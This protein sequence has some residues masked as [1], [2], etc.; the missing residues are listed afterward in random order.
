M[1]VIINYYYGIIN[2]CH[3]GNHAPHDVGTGRKDGTCCVA[4]GGSCE[5]AER[6]TF[7]CQMRGNFHYNKGKGVRKRQ[8]KYICR[9]FFEEMVEEIV[10]R[11]GPFYYTTFCLKNN[12]IEIST[13]KSTPV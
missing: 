2:H 11:C 7:S 12:A 13:N 10:E 9:Y 8:E 5:R 4:E 6:C 1:S 3:G